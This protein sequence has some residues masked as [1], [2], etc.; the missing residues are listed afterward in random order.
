MKLKKKEIMAILWV[1]NGVS[2]TE[3]ANSKPKLIGIVKSKM[4]QLPETVLAATSCDAT[5]TI[6][7]RMES[8]EASREE[9]NIE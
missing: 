6:K 8:R 4:G 1:S 9:L 7:M 2:L 5:G 3:S